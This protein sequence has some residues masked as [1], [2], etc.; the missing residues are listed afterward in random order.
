MCDEHAMVGKEPAALDNIV[1]TAR[2]K[3]GAHDAHNLG[4]EIVV[5]LKGARICAVDLQFRIC[6]EKPRDLKGTEEVG[7]KDVLGPRASLCEFKKKGKARVLIVLLLRSAYN[8]RISNIFDSGV[9]VTN[10]T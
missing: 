8:R 1:A 9:N 6:I 5:L 7:M 10:L 3:R 2:N 4:E